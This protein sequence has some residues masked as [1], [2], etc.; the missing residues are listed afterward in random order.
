MSTQDLVNIIYDEL[1]RDP[2]RWSLPLFVAKPVATVA[3]VAASLTGIDFPIT[4]A[5]IE[6]FCTSTAFDA[7]AVREIGFAQPVANEK[8]VRKTVQ[9][10]IDQYE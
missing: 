5:R 10:Q 7:S 2:L 6:K 3:D 1:G 9:W 4:A 8:A